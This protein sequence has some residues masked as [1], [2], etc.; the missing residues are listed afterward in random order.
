MSAAQPY[1]ARAAPTPGGDTAL[2]TWAIKLS[3]WLGTEFRNVQ[4]GFLTTSKSVV[5]DYRA[6]LTDGLLLVDA[7][8]GN[9][10]IT[11]PSP[12]T[13]PNMQ[14]CIKRIDGSGNT[15]TIAGTIDATT[16]PTLA[17][18]E[19]RTVWADL[20]AP[21]GAWYLIAST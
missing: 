10:T 17:Q 9:V 18:W 5:T 2:P 8:A 6:K 19:S 13:V 3:A 15:V 20:S 12:G 14:C 7:T 16:D 21:S 1:A 11:L 4:R